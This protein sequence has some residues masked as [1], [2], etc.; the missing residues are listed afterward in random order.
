MQSFLTRLQFLV[1]HL[2]VVL[3]GLHIL[4]KALVLLVHLLVNHFDFLFTLGLLLLQTS[5]EFIRHLLEL[6]ARVVPT[7]LQTLFESGLFSFVHLL[8]VE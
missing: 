1:H 6:L 4:N 3:E 2:V 8:Q 7:L 5:V